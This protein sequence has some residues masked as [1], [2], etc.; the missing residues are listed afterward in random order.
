MLL[1]KTDQQVLDDI[2]TVINGMDSFDRVFHY[3]ET[4]KNLYEKDNVAVLEADYPV[5]VKALRKALELATEY[6]ETMEVLAFI[7][8]LHFSYKSLLVRDTHLTAAVLYNRGIS[9]R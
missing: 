7:E 1:D 5:M 8:P 6:G 9:Y 4:V 2:N 3:V